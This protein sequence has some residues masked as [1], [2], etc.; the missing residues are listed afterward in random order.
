MAGSVIGYIKNASDTGTVP[1]YRSTC[2]SNT[3]GVCTGWGLSLDVSGSAVGYL[4]TTAPDSQ[5]ATKP[6]IQSN[7]LLLQGLTGTASAYLWSA[8]TQNVTHT[9]HYYLTS[10]SAPTGYTSEGTTGYIDQS[11]SAGTVPLYRFVHSSSGHH[12][13]STTADQPAGFTNEATL[14]YVHTSSGSGLVGLH[15]HYNSTTGDYLLTTSSTPPSGYTFQA[16]L[17]YI[18][19]SSGPTGPMQDLTYAY[20][21]TGNIT[22]ITDAL[23]TGS[24]SFTYDALNRLTSGTGTFGSGQSQVTHNYVYDA[25]GNILEKAGITYSYTDAS[26]PSAVTSTSDGKSYTYDAN[27][28]TLTGAGRTM[29]W[30]VDNRLSS[31]SAAG[32]TALMSYDYTGI[33]VKKDSPGGITTYPFSG[34]EID[35]GGVVTKYIKIGNEIVGASKGGEKLFYHNDHLGGINVITDLWAARIQLAEYDPWGKVSREEG[36]GDSI[37]RFTGKMLDPESGLYYYGGRYYDPE[38]GRFISPDP[39]VPQPGDPQSFNRYSYVGNNPVNYIDPSGYKKK[40]GGFFRRFF[41][42]IVGAIVGIVSWGLGAPAMLAGAIGGATA[43]AVNS[44]INGGNFAANVFGGAF[45]GGIA[46]G[47]GP[48]LAG[49]YGGGFL[50]AVASG[51]VTGAVVGAIGTGIY[52]GKF[53]QNVGYGAL[54]GAITAAA[55]YGGYKLWQSLPDGVG[56]SAGC[57]N[58]MPRGV[59]PPGE[60]PSYSISDLFEGGEVMTSPYG[61]RGSGF[62]GGIDVAPTQGGYGTQALAPGPIQII[63][64]G[65]NPTHGDYFLYTPSGMSGPTILHGHT[66]LMSG[67]EAGMLVNKG[68]PIGVLTQTGRLTGP[69]THIEVLQGGRRWD[70]STIFGR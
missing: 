48:P 27:G 5:S 10:G 3:S 28:N 22:G 33:R 52:G 19:T 35:G 63:G 49:A 70:P 38:L 8:Q 32:G 42:A 7:G 45:L 14:G 62:H 36:I 66:A 4:S 6:F 64:G 11:S 69:N 16:T 24:R 67:L 34:Y 47:I 61:P 51:A 58:C 13:Y 55:F 46:G 17:G 37:R 53:G 21:N 39:F 18:H 40:K 12:Y 30:D 68:T 60:T 1:V 41:G 25:I 50:G 56:G 23:W 26:H 65:Y 43:G 9:D 59:A 44:G 2:Y 31:V 57:S 20:D 29:V 54:G 15:R